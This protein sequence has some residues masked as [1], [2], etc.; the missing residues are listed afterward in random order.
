MCLFSQPSALLEDGSVYLFSDSMCQMS[1]RIV[2]LII[3][4]GLAYRSR[5]Y[6]HVSKCV[7]NFE[8]GRRR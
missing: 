4:Y 7:S 1:F 6:A 5:N 2:H 8:S 3:L